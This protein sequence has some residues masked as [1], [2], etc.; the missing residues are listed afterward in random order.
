MKRLFF[1]LAIIVLAAAS[2]AQTTF[3]KGIIVN[4][5]TITNAELAKIPEIDNK[6]DVANAD[7]INIVALAYSNNKTYT[8]TNSTAETTVLTF[9]IKGGLLGA[10]G[11][12][13]FYPM[14]KT[15]NDGHT[16]YFKLKI[17]GTTIS[18]ISM[19]ST[20]SARYFVNFYNKNS[21]SVNEGFTNDTNTG[22]TFSS[23][24]KGLVNYSI[25]TANDMTVTVTITNGN[26]D[27][28][29]TLESMT[30]FYYQNT[31]TY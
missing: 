8:V 3:K 6:V 5:D 12:L 17:N 27:D 15:N 29:S 24:V 18:E 30:V 14:Y 28:T 31:N 2:Q 22:G 1:L 10:N 21:T 23:T 4:G 16:K 9:T 13:H 11:G 25:N 20:V 7:T 26:I 19:T